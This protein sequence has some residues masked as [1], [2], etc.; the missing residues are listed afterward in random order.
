LNVFQWIDTKSPKQQSQC[1]YRNEDADEG[2]QS[3]FEI[4]SN[5]KDQKDTQ[6]DESTLVPH[7]NTQTKHDA[8][9]EEGTAVHVFV[10]V[11][12]P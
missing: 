7:A 12:L 5:A 2:Q 8:G 10:K 3:T 1:D 9:D 4:A 11:V 6:N